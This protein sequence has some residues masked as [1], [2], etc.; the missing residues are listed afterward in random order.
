MCV[1]KA[2][3]AIVVATTVQSYGE[4][5]HVIRHRTPN[6]Q[7][8]VHLIEHVAREQ[9]KDTVAQWHLRHVNAF[10]L[11]LDCSLHPSPHD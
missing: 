11:A 9:H 4:D 1:D 6:S 10:C 8:R 3:A 5:G 7:E 2:P